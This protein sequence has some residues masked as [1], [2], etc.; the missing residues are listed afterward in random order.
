[1]GDLLGKSL[2]G[3][4]DHAKDCGPQG[5]RLPRRISPQPARPCDKL[6]IARELTSSTDF[7]TAGDPVRKIADYGRLAWRISPRLA[8]PCDGLRIA[9]ELTSSTDFSTAGGT[10]R[11]IADYGRLARRISPELARPCE[12][13][14]A[15]GEASASPNLSTVGETVRLIAGG[16]LAGIMAINGGECAERVGNCRLGGDAED[17]ADRVPGTSV[18]SVSPGVGWAV[19]LSTARTVPQ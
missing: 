4:P 18:Q 6:R 9:R 17:D 14:R 11:W 8:R 12:G 10:M 2:H 16:T 1:M 15:A 19:T 13:L 5:K 3:L 7:S